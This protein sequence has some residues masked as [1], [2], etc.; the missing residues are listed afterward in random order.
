MP[1]SI[2]IAG[3]MSG[4]ERITKE[5]QILAQ[6]GYIILSRCH[7]KY[8]KL[9]LA[10]DNNFNGRVAE[11]MAMGDAYNIVESDITIID[12]IDKSSTGGSDAE[13]GLAIMSHLLRGKPRVIHIGPHR[14]V[15]HTLA[16]EH[17]DSWPDMLKIIIPC[18]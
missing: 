2:Y 18:L 16:R 5:A 4:Q 11:A 13:M 3:S 15:F 1:I 12:S 7:N 10:W 17:Y 9:E 14:N 6:A 8:D